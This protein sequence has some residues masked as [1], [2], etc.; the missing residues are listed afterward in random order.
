MTLPSAPFPGVPS[1][2]Y[3]SA[4]RTRRNEDQASETRQTLFGMARSTDALGNNVL[5]S[6]L[7]GQGWGLALPHVHEPCYPMTPY[8]GTAGYALLVAYCATFKPLA[9]QVNI[10]VRWAVQESVVS[11]TAIGEFE[12]RW[13]RGKLPA[14][15]GTGPNDSLLIDSW[16]SGTPGTKGIGGELIR[17]ATFLWPSDGPQPV[18]YRDTACV[19]V[20]V[21]AYIR[22][23]TGM[24]SD[25]AKVAPAWCYQ[26]GVGQV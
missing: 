17:E 12:I 10:G 16:N 21:W 14:G 4:D 24:A 22:A 1:R 6:D 25:I 5:G 7:A 3:N 26:S 13:N 15:R 23:A 11:N 9:Q 2:S 19:T 18:V 20:S 8:L